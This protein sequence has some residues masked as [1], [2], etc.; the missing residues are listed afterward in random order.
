MKHSSVP[1]D[2]N[3]HA[4]LTVFREFDDGSG[5]ICK[6]ALAKVLSGLDVG[7][8]EERVADVIAAAGVDVD[9]RINLSNFVGWLFSDDGTPLRQALSGL[10]FHPPLFGRDSAYFSV[11][12]DWAESD[13]DSGGRLVYEDVDDH[14]LHVELWGTLIQIFPSDR[15]TGPFFVTTR[16]WDERLCEQLTALNET[17]NLMELPALLTRASDLL[18]G[19]LVHRAESLVRASPEPT[20]ATTSLFRAQSASGI[21]VEEARTLQQQV[22]Q[23][24]SEAAGLDTAASTLLLLHAKWN[25]EE[26]LEF[27]AADHDATLASA[28]VALSPEAAAL[29]CIDDLCSVCFTNPPAPSL[30][31]GHGLCGECWPPFLK[32]NLESGAVDGS[33]CLRLKC[34]GAFCPLFV[35][36]NI[37]ERF[38]E[39]PDHQ[40]YLRLLSVSFVKESPLVAQCPA[41]GCDLFVQGSSRK[42]TVMCQCGSYFCFSC[43]QE[44]HEPVPCA[45]AA[46]WRILREKLRKGDTNA[47]KRKQKIKNCPN[48]DCAVPIWKNKG[49]M[50]MDCPMCKES[51]CWMCGQWGGG[52]SGRPQPHHVFKCNDEVNQFWGFTE[53]SQFNFSRSEDHL[54]SLEFAERLRK[55][56]RASAASMGLAGDLMDLACQAVEVLIEFRH[57]LA[58]SYVWRY[59]EKDPVK[60]APFEQVQSQ[61]EK[62][63]ERLSAMLEGD[64]EK[65]TAGWL[66][67]NFGVTQDLFLLSSNFDVS[68]EKILRDLLDEIR[69]DG[70]S[71][72]EVGMSERLAVQTPEAVLGEPP[73]LRVR[74]PK[75]VAKRRA[76]AKLQPAARP[77]RCGRLPRP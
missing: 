50:F 62:C 47:P 36:P 18:G 8:T 20:Q 57:V 25:G 68:P 72:S 19:T 24:L 12:A 17:P 53:G 60:T 23:R 77:R 67:T 76:K 13:A 58:W 21:D 39:P 59:F 10:Q 56:V 75:A 52:P 34:P 31:C 4:V 3:H 43:G 46:A 42:A 35:P 38:L 51:F 5:C 40:R 1:Q 30:M 48:G 44:A 54:E 49:C 37:F 2:T 70:R 55:V 11:V 61:L 69:A 27:L 64:P 74:R 63:V 32:C 9:G 14:C 22:V 41:L 29:S 73:Q 65:P 15:G 26:V 7:L 66:W 16:E 28:G 33:N 71:L 45:L 6:D